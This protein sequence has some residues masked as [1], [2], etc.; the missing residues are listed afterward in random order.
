MTPEKLLRKFKRIHL[1]AGESA[2]I[3]FTLGFDDFKLLGTAWTWKVESGEF[4]IMVG[5]S[6]E[7]VRLS[8]VIEIGY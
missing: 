7:D 3:T 1:I 8:Q 4:R 2:Q 6:S 5:A